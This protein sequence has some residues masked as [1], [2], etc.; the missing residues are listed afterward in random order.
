MAVGWQRREAELELAQLAAR[1]AELIDA[2]TRLRRQQR[3]LQRENLRL[4]QEV[5]A[6]QAK[7]IKATATLREYAHQLFG[8]QS[9]RGPITQAEQAGAA[10]SGAAL[11]ASPSS[12]TSQSDLA[13]CARPGRRRGARRG[14]R[15][16]GRHI[17][18]DLP[19]VDQISTLPEEQRT[20]PRC[21]KVY[22]PIAGAFK[23]SWVLDWT[24]CLFYR[25]LL[26]QKYRQDCTCPGPRTL[27]AP[28]PPKLIPK[29]LLS[30]QFIARTCVS[31]FWFGLPLHRML[32]AL[33]LEGAALPVSQGG[34]TG[35]LRQLLPLLEPLYRAICERVRTVTLAAADETT[36]TVFRPEQEPAPQTEHRPGWWT[37][38]FVASDAVAFVLDPHRSADVVFS[39]F[40]WDR[41]RP[42]P[43]PHLI[44]LTD[45]YSAYK[46]LAGWIVSAYCWAH[47]RRRFV[48]AALTA[49]RAEVRRWAEAWRQRIATLYQLDADRRHSQPASAAF[50]DADRTLRAHVASMQ[51]AMQRQLQREDL[52]PA[53]SDVLAS[54][55]RHWAGLTLFLDHPDVP[56]DNNQVERILRRPVVGRNNFLF[57]GS[58]WSA[59]LAE[60]L[61]SILATASRCGLNPL[62]YLHAYLQACAENGG[63]PLTAAALSR[64]LPWQADPAD[65]AAWSGPLAQ[66][67]ANPWA[68]GQRSLV[69][70]TVQPCR[71]IATTA[72]AMLREVDS[73]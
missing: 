31:K 16:T 28:P 14:H 36:A 73:S 52:C 42:P 37:W 29:G 58:P 13:T 7:L 54:L 3:V 68:A 40:G 2:N 35:V 41:D 61:W 43:Q 70:S 72:A 67:P 66:T 21:G 46:S 55:N 18:E 65:V 8:R 64:F 6:L 9:E 20:C 5:A 53:Q 44:L 12:P 17:A 23:V 47:L 59:H 48:H 15:G 51:A 32:A 60:M 62:T 34:L 38:C 11:P 30:T 45:C 33:Q 49:Q 27:V 26:R 1:N 57:F 63:R 22:A 19:H 56:L 69:R 25:R 10:A 71:T 39:F 50:Q 24:V 4:R